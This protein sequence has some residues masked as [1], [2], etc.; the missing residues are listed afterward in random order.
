MPVMNFDHYTI[1][2]LTT[3]DLHPYFSMI[4]HNR[5]R[6]EDYFAGTVS[7]TL[8]LEDTAKFLEENVQ[9][10]AD[11]TY[12]PFIIIDNT[13][14]TFIGYIDLKRISWNIPKAELGCFFDERYA[15]KGIATKALQ[16]ATDYFFNEFGIKKLFL[17]THPGNTAAR[18]IAEKC[19]FE[20]EGLIRCDHITT[21]GEIVDLL[22]YGKVN[23][24]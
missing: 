8:T 18:R 13:D 4:E 24:Q 10:A 20:I 15:G 17:R 23:P 3:G 11:R 9:K 14:D 1:K 21:A 19:G 6:L 12:F 5:P 16:L 7:K 22:Y 2:L